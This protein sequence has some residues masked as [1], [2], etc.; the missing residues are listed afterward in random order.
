LFLNYFNLIG[1]TPKMMNGGTNIRQIHQMENETNVN[2]NQRGHT[3]RNL[4]NNQE[5]LMEREIIQDN[6]FVVNQM[7][8]NEILLNQSNSYHSMIK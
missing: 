5:F 7:N 8:V 3:D 6:N 2:A 4:R 1:L